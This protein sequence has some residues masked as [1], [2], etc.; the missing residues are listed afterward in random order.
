[1]YICILF[2]DYV[3]SFTDKYGIFSYLE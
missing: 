3:L 2:V 1:M